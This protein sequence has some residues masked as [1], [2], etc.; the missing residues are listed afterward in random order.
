M[1]KINDSMIQMKQ[2]FK[3]SDFENL[4]HFI[5]QLTANVIRKLETS[6]T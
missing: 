1:S 2:F 6:E 4:Y 5:L 3:S